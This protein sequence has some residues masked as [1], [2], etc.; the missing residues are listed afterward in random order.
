MKVTVGFDE[1]LAKIGEQRLKLREELVAKMR[2]NPTLKD[3]ETLRLV[4]NDITFWEH[5]T[6]RSVAGLMASLKESLKL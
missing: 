4:E 2:T 5:Q 3:S 6:D 1:K